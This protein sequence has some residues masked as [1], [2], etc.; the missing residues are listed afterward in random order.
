[1]Y[2]NLIVLENMAVDN[3]KPATQQVEVQIEATTD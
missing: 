1:M 3:V 2:E